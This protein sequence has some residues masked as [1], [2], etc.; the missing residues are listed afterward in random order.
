[1]KWDP[2]KFNGL[3]IIRIPSKKIWLPDLV[4]YNNAADYLNYRMVFKNY[5]ISLWLQIQK[6]RLVKDTNAMIT[7]TGKIF[8]PVPTKLQSTCKFDATFFPFDIQRCNIKI[9]N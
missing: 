4:L 6:L 3:K 7:H 2:E 9:G 5:F 8:W 1:M